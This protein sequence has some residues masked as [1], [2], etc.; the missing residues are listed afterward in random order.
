MEIIF[1]KNKEAISSTLSKDFLFNNY[2]WYKTLEQGIKDLKT[3]FIK[4]KESFLPFVYK[5]RIFFYL[6]Y[7]SAFTTP[8]RFEK[9]MDFNHFFEKL[10]KILFME[11]VD[12]EN[13]LNLSSNFIK[14]NTF[15][16]YID[17][18][19]DTDHINRSYKKSLREQIRQAERKGVVFRKMEKTDLDKFYSIYQK[20]SI[21]K[22]GK[23]PYPLSFMQSIFDNLIPKWAD[24]FVA[25][26][27]NKITTGVICL[28]VKKDFS[29]A[30]IQGTDP[31][32]YNY[33]VSSFIFD[34]IIKYYKQNKFKYFSFGLTPPE[35]QGTLFF[36]ESFGCEKQGITIWRLVHPLYKLGRRLL[37]FKLI[38]L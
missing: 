12:F 33:R 31:D 6:F 27:S 13:K 29:L 10:R 5:K 2:I 18:K 36:K 4:H 11:L 17:L 19:K 30:F 7:F 9:D 35:S 37:K 14:I 34:R 38:S 25:E 15:Y 21:K 1:E 32:Y 24:A 8:Y 22:F 23:S 26:V 20:L 3:G 28:H 16:Q